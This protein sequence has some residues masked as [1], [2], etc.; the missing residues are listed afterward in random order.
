MG[1]HYPPFYGESVEF[2]EKE[3]AKA[4]KKIS[5]QEEIIVACD[6]EIAKINVKKD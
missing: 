5:K 2:Y 1:K 6:A 4:L 3:K